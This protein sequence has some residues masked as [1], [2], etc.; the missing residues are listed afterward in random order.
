[1]SYSLL[2]VESPVPAAD[3]E[4]WAWIEPRQERDTETGPVPQAYHDLIDQL[5]AR[6][7]CV[8]DL[9]DDEVDEAV[10]SDGPLRNNASPLLTHL[11]ISWPRVP[12]VAPFVVS[13]AH[14]LGLTVFDPQEGLI[15]RPPARQR[16]W[17]QFWG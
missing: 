10:W 15:H 7:P 11:G 16:R 6:Y 14:A 1:M 12:E 4:A 13:T 17:W 2:I 3:A 5:T 9:P 8:C